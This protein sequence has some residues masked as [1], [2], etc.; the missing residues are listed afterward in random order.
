M[1]HTYTDH[2]PAGKA[3]PEKETAELQGPSMAA[4]RTGAAAPTPNQK[5]NPVDLPNAMRAKMEN[6][7]GADLSAVKLYESQAVAD[8]GAKAITQGSEIAFAPGLLDFTSFGGQSLLGHEISHV[9]SQ[10]RGEVTGGGF[11]NDASLEARADR[12]GAMAAAGQAVAMPT[13]ALSPVTAAAAAGPMQAKDKEKPPEEVQDVIEPETRVVAPGD[14]GDEEVKKRTWGDPSF[15][16]S[17]FGAGH[18]SVKFDAIREKIVAHDKE[19]GKLNS[20]IQNHS[21][22]LSNLTKISQNMFASS[23]SHSQ[24]LTN[25]TTISGIMGS[26]LMAT[27]MGGGMAQPQQPQRSGPPKKPLPPNPN[28]QQPAPEPQQ[29]GPPKKPL[30]P[31]PKQQ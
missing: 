25:L 6:A 24:Q 18:T 22:Q 14:T 16:M 7:F 23:Q 5:G 17:D 9:V 3:A 15:W 10:A 4:L 30:P 1:D 21:Q 28:Q 2:K 12:E 27:M 20:V 31:N 11:L 29:S 13:A 8:A 19:I 26:N